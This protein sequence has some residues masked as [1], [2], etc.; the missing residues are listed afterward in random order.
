MSRDKEEERIMSFTNILKVSCGIFILS[1]PLALGMQ[2]QTPCGTPFCKNQGN[3]EKNKKV[4]VDMYKCPECMGEKI[5]TKTTIDPGPLVKLYIKSGLNNE[6]KEKVGNS[7]NELVQLKFLSGQKAELN[8]NFPLEKFAVAN[9]KVKYI[10][11][12]LSEL[13]YHG[14]EH[15]ASFMRSGYNVIFMKEFEKDYNNFMKSIGSMIENLDSQDP[16]NQKLLPYLKH[17]SNKEEYC[18]VTVIV[19]QLLFLAQYIDAQKKDETRTEMKKVLRNIVSA[20][21]LP[22]VGES[23]GSLCQTGQEVLAFT[24]L[25]LQPFEDAIQ[26]KLKTSSQN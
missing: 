25:F 9:Q 21:I 22:G 26:I 18:P 10:F 7:L 23:E 5:E 19:S 24:S 8:T 2:K 13:S 15:F 3:C 11:S 6:L 17:I 16:V 1:T 12:L 20:G 4:C 14:A